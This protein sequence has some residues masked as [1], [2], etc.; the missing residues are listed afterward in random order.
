MK[1]GYFKF[2]AFM[3]AVAVGSPAFAASSQSLCPVGPPTPASYTWNFPGEASSLL[4]QIK[5]DAV[6]VSHDADN[7]QALDR[8]ASLNFWQYDAAILQPERDRINA[9]DRL[10]CRLETIRRL[11]SPAEQKAIDRLAPSVL[12]LSES[13]REA[14]HYV[15]EHQDALMFQPYTM[16]AGVMYDEA[17]RVVSAVNAYERYAAEQP[18][19][20]VVPQHATTVSGS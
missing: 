18:E 19:A 1:I 20:Q 4:A 3:L 15:N 16:Q 9:M 6:Q 8:Q 17:N 11:S 13:A 14:I 5:A 2:A 7:L 10:L 12:E